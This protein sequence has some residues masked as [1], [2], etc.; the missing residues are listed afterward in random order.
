M[1]ALYPSKTHIGV[2][3]GRDDLTVASRGNVFKDAE[4]VENSFAGRITNKEYY[5]VAGYTTETRKLNKR[6]RANGRS[7]KSRTTR[8]RPRFTSLLTCW[9]T[10]GTSCP[11]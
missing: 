1:Q 8:L 6:K 2:D 4:H 9:S 10:C 3:P 5:Q 11:A 7:S